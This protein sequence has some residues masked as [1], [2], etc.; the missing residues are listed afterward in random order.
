MTADHGICP[1]PEV[2]AARGLDARR[3]SVKKHLADAELQLRLLLDP[4]APL[5]EK[6]RYIENAAGQWVYLNHKLIESKGLKVAEVARILAR[7]LDRQEGVLRT[8]TRA[9][10]E[11]EPDRYDAIGQR[12]RKAY[13]PDRC[14]DVAIVLKPYWLDSDPKTG[15]AHHT[16]LP[17]PT[18][19]TC[20][21]SYLDQTLKPGI[22]RESS[23]CYDREASSPSR[24]A[25][26][27]R[28]R[29]STRR[30][31]YCSKTEFG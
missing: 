8:F 27:R 25:S 18:T 12:M 17:T 2:S 20:R 6:T 19:H 15:P 7:F 13:H 24:L 5:A 1:L 11:T 28:R 4:E 9:Q 14:G 26:P 29:L 16:V 22:R 31:R 10:L 23:A 21:C 3:V 30:R